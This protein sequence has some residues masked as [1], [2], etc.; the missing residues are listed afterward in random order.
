MTTWL[1]A[2]LIGLVLGYGTIFL[3]ETGLV[4]AAI[5]TLGLAAVYILQGRHRDVGLLLIAEGVYPVILASW[6]LWDAA[7][8]PDTEVGPDMTLI[9]VGGLLAIGV[10]VVLTLA[11]SVRRPAP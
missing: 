3:R 9:L 8:Q 10:G 11:A 5:V 4:I 7:T 2:V 1:P 6:A